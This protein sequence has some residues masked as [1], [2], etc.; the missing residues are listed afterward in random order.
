MRKNRSIILEVFYYWFV[1]SSIFVG[2]VGCSGSDYD[3]VLKNEVVVMED[4]VIMTTGGLSHVDFLIKTHTDS[5]YSVVVESVRRDGKTPN[6]EIEKVERVI[7]GKYRAYFRDKCVLNNYTDLVYLS[8][9]VGGVRLVSNP[10][11]VTLMC[12]SLTKSLL[13]TG[14]PL[15]KIETENHEMPTCE[16][17]SHPEG[18]VGASIINATKVPGRIQ[19]LR[20][21]LVLYNSGPY[22]KSESGMTIKIR[23]N[24][25]AY[26]EKKPYK[27]K[28]QKKADLLCRGNDD[29]YKDKDWLLINDP[30]FKTLIGLKVNEL[31]NMQW[32]P[33]Y[34]YVNVMINGEYRGLYILIESVK[35]NVKCRLNVDDSGYV[36]EYDAYWWKEGTYVMNNKFAYNM[37]YTF[38]YPDS[39]DIT[40]LQLETFKHLIY[41][42]QESFNNNAYPNYLDVES[43]ASW[44]LGQDI[45]GNS[46]P[47]GSNIYLTKKDSTSKT[48]FVMANMWDFDHTFQV[49]DDWS[50]QH[51]S[52][53]FCFGALFKSPNKTFINEYK[54][55]WDDICPHLFDDVDFFLYSLMNSTKGLSVAKSL[56]YSQQRW[57]GIRR[58]EEIINSKRIWLKNR[59]EWLNNNINAIGN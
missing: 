6:Y 17:V 45:L 44:M 7:G 28:L 9:N 59:K 52:G 55:K 25:S 11:R 15:F 34:S 46:D 5:L 24:T 13:E 40:E 4:S 42:F 58:F 35:R 20:D 19:L 27:I 37:Q 43:F 18:C 10:F 33:S 1:L 51:T 36:F 22:N 26:G 30:E 23:G 50:A 14:L 16:Y 47:C 56:E 48:K 31:L 29:V 3:D 39:D 2:I 12:D 49:N 41:D 57:G 53:I 8:L 38:K 21:S 32:T 54:R